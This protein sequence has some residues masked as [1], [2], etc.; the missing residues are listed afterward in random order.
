MNLLSHSLHMTVRH[1]R[2]LVRQP[3][4]IAVSLVQPLIWLLLFGS[5]F[6]GIAAMPGF[7]TNAYLD[8]LAP[9]IV[10][11]SAIMSGGWGGMS[12]YAD[13]D[14]GV[15]DRFLVSPA[16]RPALVVG[17]LAQQAVIITIQSLV[18]IGLATLA[19]AA[20]PGG[21][22]G[23]AVTLLAAV[24]VGVG[25]ASLSSALVLTTRREESLVIL[26]QLLAL[27][28]TFLSAAFMPIHLA[29]D[30]IAA[31]APYNPA[32]WAVVIARDALT[33]SV[34]QV[35]LAWNAA[36]LTAFVI[37]TTALATTTFRAYQRSL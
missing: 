10:I 28:L 23:I 35:Q 3:W 32:Q 36:Y 15:T 26:V 16:R 14:R 6:S 27:P 2:G 13:L 30:W 31:I 24:L 25:F 22:S 7:E 34:D 17:P 8:F 18:I 20:F 19:G 5:L 37:A 12:T 33:G 4:M 21:A 29:P 11:M 9:G 1:L